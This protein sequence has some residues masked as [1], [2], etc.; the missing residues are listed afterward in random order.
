MQH[1]EE[2]DELLQRALEFLKKIP[3]PKNF[4]PMTVH[5]ISKPVPSNK[6]KIKVLIVIAILVLIIKYLRKFVKK[7]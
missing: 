6:G 4:G 5:P 3:N 1:D 2:K 7:V